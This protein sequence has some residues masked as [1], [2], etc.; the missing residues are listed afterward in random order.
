MNRV[1]YYL[2]SMTPNQISTL[3]AEA[4]KRPL[5]IPF[6]LQVFDMFKLWRSTLLKNTIQRTPS[7]RNAFT[8]RLILKTEPYSS[9]GCGLPE[10]MDSARTIEKVP[11][12][13]R[14]GQTP[15]D[16]VGGVTAKVAYSYGLPAAARYLKKGKYSQDTVYWERS[17]EHVILSNP[18]I[19]AIMIIDVF[20]DPLKV[21]ELQCAS[22]GK[23]CDTWNTDYPATT[24]DI[25]QQAIEYTIQQILNSPITPKDDKELSL[26][27]EAPK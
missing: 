19:G 16:F 11:S 27:T 20:D 26:N 21:A 12:A 9:A 10:C 24:G 22:E 23:P 15:Y 13:I 1:F 18:E 8:Q 6:K 4:V 3:I 7:M 2:Y 25:L 14:A 5:D 17:D